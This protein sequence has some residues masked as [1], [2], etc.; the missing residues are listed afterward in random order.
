MTFCRVF[1]L[2]SGRQRGNRAGEQ[3]DTNVIEPIPL[4]KL[5]IRFSV[6][7]LSRG[8]NALIVRIGPLMFTF[9]VSLSGER[10]VLRRL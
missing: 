4:L 6:P 10:S 2:F 7:A 5:M 3:A 8:R 9:R 1:L